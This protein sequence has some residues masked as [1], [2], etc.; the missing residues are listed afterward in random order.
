MPRRSAL[1]CSTFLFPFQ[2]GQLEIALGGRPA[3]N[4]ITNRGASLSLIMRT[5]PG[6]HCRIHSSQHPADT[7]PPACHEPTACWLVC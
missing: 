7:D 1:L 6:P 2:K 5:L 4:H 3:P